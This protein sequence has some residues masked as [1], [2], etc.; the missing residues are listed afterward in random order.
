MKTLYVT[1]I[2]W[3]VFSS[4]VSNH[5]QSYKVI[6]PA[7]FEDL[8]VE[9]VQLVDVRTAEEY[10]H[11]HIN[12]AINIDFYDKD[13]SKNLSSK[14]TKKKKVLVYCR[15]GGRSKKASHH[16]L[17]LGFTE[18]YDLEGGFNNWQEHGLDVSV[19]K[20]RK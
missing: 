4:C 9:E 16:L 11:G 2:S 18:I 13:F 1:L 14:L 6:S 7:E 10:V 8:L 5:E 17:D 12:D 20:K 19:E 3:I 15:S